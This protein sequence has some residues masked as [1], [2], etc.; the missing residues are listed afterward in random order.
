MH[1]SITAI[2]LA[3][4]ANFVIGFIFHSPPLG[5]IWMKLANIKPTGNEKFAD[6]IPAMIKNLAANLVYA[7]G[8]AIIYYLAAPNMGGGTIANG[9]LLALVIWF[10][11]GLTATVIDVIWLG[12]SPHLWLYEAGCSFVTSIAMGIIIAIFMG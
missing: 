1:F 3:A 8:I 5:N 11:F 10:C 12:K 4:I 9:I 6:M 7:L 2:I